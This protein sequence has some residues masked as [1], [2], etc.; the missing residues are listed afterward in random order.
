MSGYVV[1]IGEALIDLIEDRSQGFLRP[2]PGGSVLNVAVGVARL[3]VSSEFLG[4]FGG[5]GFADMLRSFL[6]ENN[7]GNLGSV[8]S[9]LPTSLAVTTFAGADPSFAFY[10][11][12]PSY[13]LLRPEDLDKGVLQGAS[14]IHTGSIGLL[15]DPMYRAAAAAFSIDGP[16]KTIDPNV[17]LSLIEDR[18]SFR[19]STE[20]LFGMVDLVKLSSEDATALYPGSLGEIA[21]RI[22]EFGPRAVIVT[23]GPDGA[24]ANFAGDEVRVE[25]RSVDAIDTTGAGDAFMAAVITEIV[26]CGFPTTVDDLRG[27]LE[28]AVE[29][30]ALTCCTSGG[31]TAIPTRAEVEAQVRAP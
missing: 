31:S 23:L 4:S 25:G 1:S 6:K 28:F 11:T 22:A 29:V 19:A 8:D 16:V 9:E 24:L 27:M 21:A 14:L 30:S 26:R 15:E 18:G 2:V 12:P 10:G 20:R 7:V 17:R 5:D 13:G 3:G